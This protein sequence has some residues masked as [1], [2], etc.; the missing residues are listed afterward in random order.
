M[1]TFYALWTLLAL[2][3]L[4][5]CVLW[6]NALALRPSLRATVRALYATD[7]VLLLVAVLVSFLRGV[8]HHYL[9]PA[10]VGLAMV[11]LLWWT[12]ELDL[13]GKKNNLTRP[14][15]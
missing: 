9:T 12:S 5:V 2:S 4:A 8:D 7:M 1:T 14:V 10:L 6:L 11:P 3:A 13:A 15:A